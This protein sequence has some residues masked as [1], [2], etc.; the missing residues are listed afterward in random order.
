MALIF[1]LKKLFMAHKRTRPFHGLKTGWLILAQSIS[2]AFSE[3]RDT[4]IG[5]CLEYA[6]AIYSAMKFST[7]QYSSFDD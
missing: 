4:Y 3:I 2:S 1:Y 7:V 6:I 5:T